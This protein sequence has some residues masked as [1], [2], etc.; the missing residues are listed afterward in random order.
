MSKPA[1]KERQIWLV[2]FLFSSIF[3]LSPYTGCCPIL[4]ADTSLPHA[5]D[6]TNNTNSHQQYHWGNHQ[7]PPPPPLTLFALY[8]S[9]FSLHLQ[10]EMMPAA[11]SWLP[12]HCFPTNNHHHPPPTTQHHHP[13]PST[14]SNPSLLK[15]TP[16][17]PMFK[18]ENQYKPS[19]NLDY[20]WVF[21]ICL[22]M[23]IIFM[24]KINHS[25]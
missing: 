9:L 13:P 4:A 16:K 23:I 11:L 7:Q 10:C 3:S 6:T 18:H 12:S 24:I 2:F 22:L 17:T 5:T 21:G 25:M 8:L 1:H 20:F 14:T 19:L 15:A